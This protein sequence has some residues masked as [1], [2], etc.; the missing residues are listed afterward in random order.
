MRRWASYN[1]AAIRAIVRKYN[2]GLKAD[3]S[4]GEDGPIRIASDWAKPLLNHIC[5]LLKEGVVQLQNTWSTILML[6][7]ANS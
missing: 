3:K 4:T 7:K 5:N 1:R 6:S 2:P